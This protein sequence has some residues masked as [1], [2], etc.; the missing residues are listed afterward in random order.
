MGTYHIE[1]KEEA[2]GEDH[3]R[4][5]GPSQP[6]GLDGAAQASGT[7]QNNGEQHHDPYTAPRE[8]TPR[9]KPPNRS[10]TDHHQRAP[11][12]RQGGER[13]LGVV[14]RRLHLRVLEVQGQ[15]V[16]V[17][18]QIHPSSYDISFFFF[19]TFSKI[20]FLYIY[21]INS[22]QFVKKKKSK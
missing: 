21:W 7:G 11:Q 16:R 6:H 17:T 2:E 9:L 22:S 4:G 10:G 5:K 8:R 18:L 3:E 19:F 12:Q 14:E 20:I 13:L 1:E 15:P